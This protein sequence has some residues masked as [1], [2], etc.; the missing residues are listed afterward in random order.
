MSSLARERALVRGERLV[1]APVSSYSAPSSDEPLEVVGVLR[2]EDASRAPRRSPCA[3]Y[4]S[5]ITSRISRRRPDCPPAA[6]SAR[7]ARRAPRPSS[8]SRAS[9]VP[10]VAE[11]RRERAIVAGARLA[12]PRGSSASARGELAA[13]EELAPELGAREERALRPLHD[14][15]VVALGGVVVVQDRGADRASVCSSCSRSTSVWTRGERFLVTA[16]ARPALSPLRLEQAPEREDRDGVLRCL[17]DGLLV[18]RRG[19]LRFARRERARRRARPAQRTARLPASSALWP[20]T[21][22]RACRGC[23]RAG[24]RA[25]RAAPAETARLDARRRAPCSAR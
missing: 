19:A 13:V 8:P 21:P 10:E 6:A 2:L 20:R 16:A 3:R 14:F 17:G 11:R 15:V 5:A 9:A 1:D 22:R 25:R 7:A 24:D 23:R 12:R 4:T 18:R